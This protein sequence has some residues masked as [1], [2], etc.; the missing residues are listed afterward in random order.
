MYVK[1]ILRD[2]GNAVFTVTPETS[3][4]EFAKILVRRR[5]G[6]AVVV[7]GD[8]GVV[9]VVSER[10]IVHCVAE[11]GAA[12]ADCSVSD[13]MTKNVHTGTPETMID[14]VMSLMTERRIRHLPVIEDGKIV[15]IVSI[16]DVVKDRIASVEREA[17]Q[18]RDY[19]SA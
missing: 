13:V 6:A 2:K 11:R 1:D 3:L 4:A 7:D 5:I 16:G 8:G 12:A 15:G 17:S 9:G 10:D 19:I 18:L 14:E